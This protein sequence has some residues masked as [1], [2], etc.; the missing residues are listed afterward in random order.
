MEL[1]QLIRDVQD[2][3][4]PGVGYRDVLPMLADGK[5][6]AQVVQ[7]MAAPWRQ[8]DVQANVQADVQA[9]VQVVAGIEAR[10]FMLAGALALTL[11]AG[12]MPLRKAGK[13]PGRVERVAYSLEYGE[14]VLEAQTEV[15]L[16]GT[17]VLLIDDVLATGGTLRAALELMSRLRVKVVGVGVMLELGFL[18]GRGKL[19]VALPVHTLFRE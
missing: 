19:P 14:A 18:G 10:G 4:K 17:R 3:P 1:R 13:L 8:L 2:F 12:F 15:L 7:Q 6:F 9:N 11:Q 5:A 16:P